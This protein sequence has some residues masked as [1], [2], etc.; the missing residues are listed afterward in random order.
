MMNTRK[1]PT[2]E[3]L[4]RIHHAKGIL[5]TERFARGCTFDDDDCFSERPEVS[6]DL[7]AVASSTDFV[8]ACAAC[9]TPVTAG[10]FSSIRC[11]GRTIAKPDGAV[12]GYKLCDACTTKRDADPEG[13]E[14][15]V[16]A[17]LN[18]DLAEMRKAMQ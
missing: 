15:I 11:G 10:P 12:Y 4:I 7:L 17:S 16:D 1:P 18:K 6:D 13:V 14:A 5:A 8:T 3:E 2:D 9:S